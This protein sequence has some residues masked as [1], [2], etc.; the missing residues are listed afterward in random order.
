MSPAALLIAAPAALAGAWYLVNPTGARRLEDAEGE[1]ASRARV[2]LR[3]AN[4]LLMLAAAVLLYFAVSRTIWLADDDARRP[5]LALPL[6]WIALA[7]AAVG[8][9]LMAW[10][11]VRLTRRLK[12]RE[13]E[14][15]HRDAGSAA[16]LAIALLLIGCD[17]PQPQPAAPPPLPPP[18]VVA[19][20]AEPP[21]PSEPEPEAEADGEPQDLP[22][23]TLQLGD[24]PF[25][26]MVADT[27]AE[28]EKGLMFRREMGPNQGMLFVFP[29]REWRGFWMRNTPLPLDIAFLN[30]RGQVLNVEP[31]RPF[32]ERQVRS[33]GRAMFVIEL[34]L[35][36]AAQVGLRRGTK[37]DIPADVVSQD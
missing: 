29:G 19:T 5:G 33:A 11:D 10:L 7:P 17:D 21:P 24:E 35:G 20:A 22:T 6:A 32:D 28:R 9:L 26:L 34:N 14:T 12:R 36:R 25:E 8:M 30:H 4:G 2:R 16:L 18:A 1:A 27:T 31:A 13:R 23:I 37:V 3:R 15:W